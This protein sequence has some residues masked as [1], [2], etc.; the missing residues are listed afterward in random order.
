VSAQYLTW[1]IPFAILTRDKKVISFSLLGLLAIVSFYLFFE[2]KIL[3]GSMFTIESKNANTMSLY[4][5]S[6]L[7]FF[8]FCA[9]WLVRLIKEECKKISSK[10]SPLR[11]NIIYIAFGVYVILFVKSL[12]MLFAVI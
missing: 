1:I 4:A 12:I 10:L 7:A 6:N 11:K 3:L 9:N 8:L 2:P 5:F